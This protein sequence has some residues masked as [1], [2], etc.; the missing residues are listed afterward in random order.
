M[1]H[2]TDRFL[3]VARV[4]LFLFLM[5]GV[6]HASETSES[7]GAT[8]DPSSPRNV[9]LII[10]DGMDDHQITIARNYLVGAQG[11]LTLDLLIFFEHDRPSSDL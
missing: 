3:F 7:Q 4:I 11:R 6:A 2:P 1:F 8:V 5:E 10:G 9:I